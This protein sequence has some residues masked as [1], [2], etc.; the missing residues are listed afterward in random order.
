M[1]MPF[2]TIAQSGGSAKLVGGDAK[3]AHWSRAFFS[4]KVQ[5]QRPPSVSLVSLVTDPRAHSSDNINSF[6]CKSQ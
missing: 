1:I 5:W 2:A 3:L 4:L 6:S